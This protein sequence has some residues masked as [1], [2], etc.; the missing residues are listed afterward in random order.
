MTDDQTLDPD[1]QKTVAARLDSEAVRAGESVEHKPPPLVPDVVVD[2]YRLI[3][4]LGEGGFGVVYLVSHIKFPSRRYA[5]K[6]VKPDRFTATEMKARF[7]RE[8]Q[9][10]GNLNHPH[11]VYATDAG[12]WNGLPYLVMDYVEGIALN[13]LL[14]NSS[15]LTVAATC[16]MMR[17]VA[18]G[19]QHVHEKGRTHRDQK[20][21]NLILDRSG[22]VR[23]LDLGLAKLRDDAEADGEP[24]TASGQWMGSPDYMAPEQWEDSSTVDIRADIY[25]LGCTLFC[26]LTGRPPF[27]DGEHR[28][29]VAK[30]KGHTTEVAADI[31]E[32]R[33]GIVPGLNAIVQKCLTKDQDDRF[34]TPRELADALQTFCSADDLKAVAA[35]LHTT[36]ETSPT[37]MSTAAEA[38]LIATVIQTDHRPGGPE[39]DQP[40]SRRTGLKTVLPQSGVTLWLQIGL[41]VLLGTALSIWLLRTRPLTDVETTASTDLENAS[42]VPRD[43]QTRRRTKPSKNDPA[44]GSEDVQ[45]LHSQRRNPD[46]HPIKVEHF[47]AD[48]D[49]VP[50][51]LG[52]IG[53]EDRKVLLNDVVRLTVNLRQKHYVH[54]VA[55]NTDGSLQLLV[56]TDE[57]R[58]PRAIQQLQFPS[59]PDLYFHLTDGTGQHAF[60]VLTSRVPLPA[61]S[62]LLPILESAGWVAN[63]QRGLWSFDGSQIR[64]IFPG[65]KERGSG[66]RLTGKHFRSLCLAVKN[67]LPEIEVLAFAFPVE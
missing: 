65:R 37:D 39:D 64:Q 5:L 6:L 55:L 4:K 16:E 23:I 45:A 61:F 59:E 56:P 20:P 67:A 24:L 15:P 29:T 51:R 18:T 33:V 49:D 35:S 43:A 46:L 58:A 32:L 62:E 19:M 54:V 60:L 3:R 25:S 66:V 41:T 22:V 42:S 26:L 38:N 30:M 36:P 48:A 21:S 57:S 10:M 52:Q 53:I 2:R 44:E 17:Q 28:S 47:R 27:G 13:Q 40:A 1:R 50:R 14:R 12:E 34:Q 63:T 31:N 11:V 8:I 7:S 9:A